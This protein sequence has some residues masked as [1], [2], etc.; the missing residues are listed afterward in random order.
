MAP[1][2][3]A[4]WGAYFPVRAVGNYVALQDSHL[5]QQADV[6]S[7][8]L[9]SLKLTAHQLSKFGLELRTVLAR[10]ERPLSLEFD[11]SGGDTARG[12]DQKALKDCSGSP[13]QSSDTTS[14]SE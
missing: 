14:T 11:L 12:P 1:L 10:F 3:V 2:A 8:L 6:S 5:Q 7:T 13:S 9:A 4:R